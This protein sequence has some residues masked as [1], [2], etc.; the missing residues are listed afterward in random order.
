MILLTVFAFL[1][2]F[3]YVPDSRAQNNLFPNEIRGYEF[4]GKGKLNGLQLGV[5][6]KADIRELFG[7]DC[8][9]YCEYD[10]NWT[11]SFSFY[12]DDLTREEINRQGERITYYLD[13]K[14]IGTLRKIEI[15]PKTQIS[16]TQVS[17]PNTFKRSLK[18]YHSS[19]SRTKKSRTIAHQLFQ[20]A[21]GLTYELHTTTN[22]DEITNDKLNNEGDLFSIQYSISKEQERDMFILQKTG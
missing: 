5:S 15:R 8:E 22:Y 20:D 19:E 16:F 4:F 18:N 3:V 9:Y 12:E 6:T 21:N 1:L 17:F 2:S 11:I 13:S 14:Y 7:K 10:E